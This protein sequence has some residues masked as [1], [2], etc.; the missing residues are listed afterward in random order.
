MH[1]MSI[2]ERIV[3]VLEEQARTHCYQRVKKVWLEI[4]P[5]AGVELE[6]LRFSF[7]VVARGTLTEGAGLEIIQPPG[8]AWCLTC[9]KLVAIRERFDSCPECGGYRLRV[10]SGDQLRIKELQVE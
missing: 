6:A 9:D 1:E 8:E 5:L 4:G 2:C 10:T 3:Q 7:E